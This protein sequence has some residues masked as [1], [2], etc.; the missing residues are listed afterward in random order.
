MKRS[1]KDDN[2]VTC[3]IKCLKCCL[4]CCEKFVKFFNKHA[5][6][7]VMLNS[8][9]FCTSAKSAMQLVASN[10]IR[11]GVLHGLGAIIMLFARVFIIGV[12]M[13]ISYL[14]LTS[15]STGINAD[16]ATEMSDIIAPFVVIKY[17]PNSFLDHFCLHIC[18]CSSLLPYLGNFS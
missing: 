17:S 9:N 4:S 12:C 15:V 16:H 10:I 6:T 7:E 5:Y 11:F 1:K 13:T 8:T 14:S 2:M 3:M 18:H